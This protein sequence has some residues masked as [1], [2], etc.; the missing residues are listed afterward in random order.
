VPHDPLDELYS[1]PPDQF[2]AARAKLADQ[3]VDPA[4][5]RE[6]T[7]LRKP[8]VAAWIV[9]AYVLAEPG[10]V[11]SLTE[12]GEQLRAAQ[13]ALDAD[14][15]RELSAQRRQLV[16][17]LAGAALR[18]ADRADPPAAL[19]DEVTGTFDAALA[20]PGI[21]EQLGRLNR[22]VQWSG[23]GFPA[24]GPP[25]L[26]VVRGGRDGKPANAAKKQPAASPAERRKRKREL[27]AAQQAFDTAE[28]AFATARDTEQDL[29]A[30]VR[31]LS[32]KLARV[33]EELDETRAALEAARKE[34]G[35]ARTRRRETRSALDRAER[36]SD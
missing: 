35:E 29:A 28:S 2:L 9:N 32:T 25:Q 17:T 12:L 34:V 14:A 15:L 10:V 21:A 7:K 26:T 27:A 18:K 5:A 6:I 4:A 36:A 33:Q 1:V 16:G 30:R 24:G 31:K 23:F 13:G 22:A 11:A 19:R 20:D 3:A 8:T